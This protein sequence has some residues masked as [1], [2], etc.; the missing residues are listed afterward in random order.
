MMNLRYIGDEKKVSFIKGK[1]YSAKKISDKFGE[2]YAI[3]D[4]GDDW[5]R[6]GVQFVEKNF[7]VLAETEISGGI[8]SEPAL[9]FA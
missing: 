2:C 9:R 4:E 1:V 8:T 6:Y 7:D 3:F 5:Y